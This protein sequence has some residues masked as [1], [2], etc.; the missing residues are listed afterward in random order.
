MINQTLPCCPQEGKGAEGAQR[1]FKVASCSKERILC[2][3]M[4]QTK[5]AR[6]QKS[7][8]DQLG[9]SV[10]N[11]IQSQLMAVF[12][13]RVFRAKSA[14]RFK[15]FLDLRCTQSF[16]PKHCE[17]TKCEAYMQQQTAHAA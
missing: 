5:V 11:N 7:E 10:A 2:V 15:A 17:T 3:S 13:D 16:T 1:F 12:F 4:V 8:A 6:Q 14:D 9:S